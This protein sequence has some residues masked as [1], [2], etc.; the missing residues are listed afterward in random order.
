MKMNNMRVI[1]AVANNPDTVLSLSLFFSSSI[2]PPYAIKHIIDNANNIAQP[3]LYAFRL[4]ILLPPTRPFA[5]SVIL[6]NYWVFVNFNTFV[7]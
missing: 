2:T 4:L 3:K 5:T 1:I 6:N 7:S